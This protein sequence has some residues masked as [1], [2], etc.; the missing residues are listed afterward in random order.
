M[1]HLTLVGG[2]AAGWETWR[3]AG[4]PVPPGCCWAPRPSRR[5]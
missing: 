5:C 3:A 1:A 2:K 4:L